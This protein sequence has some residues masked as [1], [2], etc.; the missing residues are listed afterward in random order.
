MAHR[1]SLKLSKII[2]NVLLLIK[3]ENICISSWVTNDLSHIFFTEDL[4]MGGMEKISTLDVTIKDQSSPYLRSKK[5]DC[6][7]ERS[8]DID[9]N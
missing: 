8:Q 9:K 2:Q 7:L 6:A 4:T 5:M 1:Y 3:R